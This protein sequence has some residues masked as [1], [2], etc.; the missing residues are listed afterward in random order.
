MLLVMVSMMGVISLWD[1]AWVAVMNLC[2]IFSVI[3][4]VIA[5]VFARKPKGY[6]LSYVGGY[7]S[8]MAFITGM[9]YTYF[10]RVS[11]FMAVFI[12]FGLLSCALPLASAKRAKR[13]KGLSFELTVL[14]LLFQAGIFLLLATYCSL[15]GGMV[16]TML[17]MGSVITIAVGGILVADNLESGFV[18]LAFGIIFMLVWL[19]LICFNFGFWLLCSAVFTD[20]AVIIYMSQSILMRRKGEVEILESVK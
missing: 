4:T 13:G 6:T 12:I 18:I 1:V 2:V 8:F 9:F 11:N 20:A 10:G 14:G 5:M 7:L 17:G 19:F 15:F 16:Y 3:I